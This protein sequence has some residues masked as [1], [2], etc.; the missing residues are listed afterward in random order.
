MSN[1]AANVGTAIG[2]PARGPESL[3]LGRKPTPLVHA[4]KAR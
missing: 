1:E 3:K 2:K 4:R